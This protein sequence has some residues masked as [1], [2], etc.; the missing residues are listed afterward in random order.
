MEKKGRDKYQKSR[1]KEHRLAMWSREKTPQFLLALSVCLT[2]CK[3]L[4]SGSSCSV[5]EGEG[6]C[7]CIFMDHKYLFCAGFRYSHL[8][9][10]RVLLRLTWHLFSH[11]EDLCVCKFCCKNLLHSLW[12]PLGKKGLNFIWEFKK[13]DV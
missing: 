11:T 7:L 13:E 1:N 5:E 9:I 4:C 10:L 2:C 6:M 3:T 12:L 8:K